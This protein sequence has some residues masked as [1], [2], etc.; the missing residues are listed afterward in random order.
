[1]AS[2]AALQG[3]QDVERMHQHARNVERMHHKAGD[4]RETG[5]FGAKGSQGS[6]GSHEGSHHKSGDNLT[7]VVPGEAGA[8]G[9]DGESAGEQVREAKRFTFRQNVY[10]WLEDPESS[11]AARAFS[12]LILYTIVVS[13]ACFVLETVP[14]LRHS[15]VF[16]IVEPTTTIVFTLEYVGRFLVCDS[17]PPECYGHTS[18]CAF[19]RNPLN[20]LDLLAIA[21]FYMELAAAELMKSA[22]PLRVLRS[23]RLIRCFRIFKLSKYSLGMTI[24]VESVMNSLQPLII[25][26]F[27]LG[28]G[29]V[30]TSSLMYYAEKQGCPNV[31]AKIAA[32]VFEQYLQ[33]CWELDNGRT[34]TGELCCN[35]YGASLDFVSIRGSFWWSVVTMTTV[36]YGD[37]VPRTLAGRLVGC[38]AMLSGIVLISL[39]VA[40]VGSKFQLA[41]ES[42][43]AEK[44]QLAE[45]DEAE[46]EAY[47][48][49]HAGK[50]QDK[51]LLVDIQQAEIDDAVQHAMH[52]I[53]A[54]VH[55]REVHNAPENRSESF[56]PKRDIAVEARTHRD[57]L[58][59]SPGTPGSTPHH[60][61]AME[62]KPTPV[63]EGPNPMMISV[64]ARLKS[65]QVKDKLSEKGQ[66]ELFLLLEMFDHVEREEKKLK[67]LRDKDAALDASIR[68]EFTAL[69]RAYDNSVRENL[70]KDYVLKKEVGGCS[71]Q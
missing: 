32:G 56:V 29:V 34:S 17:F 15:P 3:V 39:P 47:M 55:M 28:I 33:E 41:Y 8:Q 1:M 46:R 6:Q 19:L 69:S 67:G 60:S 54:G 61:S 38:L 58:T 20:I 30:L 42:L 48:S 12:H 35:K 62:S 7:P 31:K 45:L 36:G 53:G 4:V 2:S 43:E 11:F 52:E 21:P 14:S 13:I 23:V 18:K 70:S 68:K 5:D 65:L 49:S 9:G 37:Q 51:D 24:M 57:A 27:F 44:R 40:I 64:R 63:V 66:D 50:D 22:K 71:T 16:K 25:L 59:L 26:T 10:L